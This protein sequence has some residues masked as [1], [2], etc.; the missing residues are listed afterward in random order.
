MSRRLLPATAIAILLALSSVPALSVAAG[1]GSVLALSQVGGNPHSNQSTAIQF[2]LPGNA[3]AVDGRIYFDTSAATMVSVDPRGGGTSFMPVDIPGGYAFGA[4]NLR[5]GAVMNV[6]FAPLTAGDLQVRID[7]DALAD[8]SGNRLPMSANEAT[9]TVKVDGGGHALGAPAGRGAPQ[10]LRGASPIRDLMANG[11]IDKMDL[12]I[13][14]VGWELARARGVTCDANSGIDGDANND[15]CIDIVDVQAVFAHRGD[16]APVGATPSVTA[17]TN[18]EQMASVGALEPTTSSTQASSPGP[19]FVVDS[20]LDTADA[21]PGDGICADTLGNCTFRAAITESNWWHGANTIAF[22]LTGVAPVQINIGTTPLPL[23]NDRSGGLTIDGYTEPGSHPNTAATGSNA[24]LGVILRGPGTASSSRN[25]L[26]IT[27]SNNVVR[28]IGFINF[29]RALV[30]DHSDATNNL[31]AGNWFGFNSTGTPYT[32]SADDNILLNSGANHNQIGT[33]ALADRNVSGRATKAIFAYG[34]GTDYNVIQ[35]NLLCAT[36]TGTNTTSASCSTGIDHDHGPQHELIG[37]S[38]TNERNVIGRTLLNGIEYS[39]G[40]NPDG[41]AGQSDSTWC[42]CNNQSIDNWVGF[43]QNGAYDVNF[44]SGINDPGTADNGNG[45]NAYDGSS[46]N[47]IEGNYV[48]SAY[49]GIQTMSSNATD[50]TIRNNIIGVS[51]LGTAAPVGRYGIVVREHTASHTVVGNTISNT[52]NYGIGLIQPDVRFIKL[53]QNIITNTTAQAIYLAPYTQDPASGANALLASPV[54]T[55]ATTI[56][57]GGTGIS[58]ATVE[59][60]RADRPAGQSGLPISYIGSTTVGS[61]GNWSLPVSIP[62]GWNVTALQIATN[63]NTS[64]LSTNVAATFQ[65]PPPPP[66][67][68]YT[69]GQQAASLTVDFTDA[70]TGSPTAWSWDF[71]DSSSSTQQ[72]PTH[73]YAAAGD[74]SVKLTASNAGGSDSVTKT[75]TVTPVSSTTTYAADAFSRTTSGGWGNAD[76]GGAYSLLGPATNFSVGSGV[77]TMVD[78]TAATTRSA[79]LN[80]A[81]GRDV[82]ISF[83][84]RADKVA[85]G[86]AYFIYAA[87]RVNGNNEYR[88]R[89]LFNANGTISAQASLVVNGTESPLGNAVVVPGLT[90]S[91]NGWIWFRAQVTGSGTTTIRVKAWADGSAEPAAWNFTTTNNAAALQSAGGVG[92]RVYVAGSA[93]T[94]PVS[95]GFDDYSVVSAN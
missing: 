76:I 44:R 45:F 22:N 13:A 69:W 52:G 74:Y 14:T 72:S 88:P 26:F 54:I 38:G 77:G 25:P 92:L 56:A 59:V 32:N 49:D 7:L 82:D 53:S 6:I 75:V 43:R 71:G 20:P 85:A 31:I 91:A 23:V 37:G 39:H 30:I 80:G 9:I 81:S 84:V 35:N 55:S 21:T 93:T 1:P 36:P 63:N 58:G 79:M 42:V 95:F 67:A 4:Y 66:T 87:A 27:S 2:R 47:L 60:Y 46:H 5:P 50:N 94:A 16:S 28:G 90:Q 65:A 61:N 78:P 89:I 68:N 34:A 62:N 24:V 33:S 86:G 73:T 83:R 8:A 70:S 57:V 29:Y 3:A 19:T 18:E 41:P 51:P 15:G 64:M 17:N 48:S 12:D 10:T 11:H 40:W